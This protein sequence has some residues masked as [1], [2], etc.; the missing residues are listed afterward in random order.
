MATTPSASTSNLQL[1][2]KIVKIK[3]VDYP[4]IF[5]DG[6]GVGQFLRRFDMAGEV[7]GASGYDKVMQV[8]SFL[9]G[10]EVVE[11]VEAMEGYEA[12]NWDLLKEEMIA[13][14]E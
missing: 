13:R 12:R 8:F 6:T 2:R 7:E 5:F 9:R 10:T 1:P 14:W 11:A 4:N 3:P